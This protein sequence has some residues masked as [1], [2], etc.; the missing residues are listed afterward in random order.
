MFN[1]LINLI[2]T[3]VLHLTASIQSA[4][5][6]SRCWFSTRLLQS[7]ECTTIRI[8]G[9]TSYSN[10]MLVVH[11]T[12]LPQSRERTTGTKPSGHRLGGTS[13]SNEK[14]NKFACQ[15]IIHTGSPPHCLNSECAQQ[16][17]KPSGH[18]L[19]GTSYMQ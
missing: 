4:H 7:R 15:L 17:A 3:L 5:N 1:S 18:R 9:G 11:P 14:R 12:T 13:Y 19:G 2:S 10:E 16:R 6:R 8:S